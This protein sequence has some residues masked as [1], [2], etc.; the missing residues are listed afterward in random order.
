MST[1]AAV[2]DVVYTLGEAD[3]TFQWAKPSFTPTECD[4]GE[5]AFDGDY[6]VTI[7]DAISAIITAN[8][9]N[10]NNKPYT[11]SSTSDEQYVGTHKI[12]VQAK[13][14]STMLTNKLEF[15]VVIKSSCDSVSV[16][17]PSLSDETWALNAA[18]KEIEFAKMVSTDACKD[19]IT[20]ALVI[21]DAIKD[22]ATAS[23]DGLKLTLTGTT[24]KDGVVAEHVITFKAVGPSGQ[25]MSNGAVTFKLTISAAAVIPD[26][27]TTTTPTGTTPGAPKLG[28][29]AKG[30]IE[31]LQNIIAI[32]SSAVA[33][34]NA[35]ASGATRGP[36]RVAG[37]SRP[38]AAKAAG[39]SKGKPA[40]KKGGS[41]SFD[42]GDSGASV[43][44]S[45]DASAEAG[46]DTSGEATDFDA[47]GADDS[48]PEFSGVDFGL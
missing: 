8:N 48:N 24:D 1:F 10:G 12:T 46:A 33:S 44:A 32:G 14:E 13:D 28:P 6:E 26:D 9:V 35:A 38:G 19:K 25:D 11:I 2:S 45:V 40:P 36:R 15:N 7:P 41:A 20:F 42:G 4:A 43:D 31:Q 23:S 16:T 27:T 30:T 22:V 37:G 29:A 47:E 39:G 3:A 21:P 5:I 18:T 34:V 17:R